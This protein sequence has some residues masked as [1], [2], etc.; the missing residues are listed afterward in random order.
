MWKYQNTDELYHYGVLGMKWGQH[1]FGKDYKY[2][3]I[4]QILLRR[5]VK[6][7]NKSDPGYNKIKNKLKRIK[8][9]DAKGYSKFLQEQKNKKIK[10]EEKKKQIQDQKKKEK[11][12]INTKKTIKNL[13]DSELKK[14]NERIRLENE[15]YRSL[16]EYTKHKQQVK[17][18]GKTATSKIISTIGTKVM[19]PAM[20]NA[21]KDV[22]QDLLT[23]IGQTT[24]DQINKSYKDAFEKEITEEEKERKI[25]QQRLKDL[26]TKLSIQQLEEKLKK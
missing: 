5:K 22:L 6:K 13:T 1:I 3:S 25:N 24:N 18:N 16:D 11:E 20:T 12:Q 19:K 21:G 23:K 4:E 2:K 9:R 10:I 15:Y 17:E 26:Q 8:K 14:L 7:T